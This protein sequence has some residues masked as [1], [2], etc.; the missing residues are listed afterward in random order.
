M[1]SKAALAIITISAAAFVSGCIPKPDAERVSTQIL[2][3]ETVPCNGTLVQ[4]YIGK[5]FTAVLAEQMRKESGA[6]QLRTGP[7]DGAV[8]MDYIA[9]RLN[10]FYDDEMLIAVVNCG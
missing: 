7:K 1:N 4:K 6:I 3:A 2:T 10:V 9:G 5:R 8:T